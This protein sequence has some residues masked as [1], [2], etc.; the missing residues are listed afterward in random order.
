M[1]EGK[2]R[3]ESSRASQRRGTSDLSSSHLVLAVAILLAI[4]YTT[5]RL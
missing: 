2:A 1:A 3:R 4:A 5:S